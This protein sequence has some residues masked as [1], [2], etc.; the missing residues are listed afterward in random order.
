[1][2]TVCWVVFGICSDVGSD[3]KGWWS[4][5][6]QKRKSLRFEDMAKREKNQMVRYE[7]L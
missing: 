6:P 3:E 4:G 1:M 5:I 7:N 2:F